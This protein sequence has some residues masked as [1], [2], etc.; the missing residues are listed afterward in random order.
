MSSQI[1]L[2]EMTFPCSISAGI[3]PVASTCGAGPCSPAMRGEML[4]Q[5]RASWS[6]PAWGT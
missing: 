6:A 1:R 4:G 3:V 2:C 5:D